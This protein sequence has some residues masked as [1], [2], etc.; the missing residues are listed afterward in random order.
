MKLLI[1]GGTG[2]IGKNLKDFFFK[3]PDFEL[4][5]PTRQQLNLLDDNACSDYLKNL[6]PDFVVHSAVDI[7]SVENS[8]KSFL[9]IFN[10]HAYFGHMIQ[11]GSGAEYD[12]RY[13]SPLMDETVFGRKIP[14]DTYGLA[15]FS[16]ANILER[17]KSK[18][19]TNLRI[20]GIYGKYED[21]SRRFISNNICRVLA[22]FPIAMN[23]NMLFD[24]IHVDD[25]ARFLVELFPKLPLPEVSYNFCSGKPISFVEL[26]EKVRSVMGVNS[27]IVIK[28]SGMNPEYS[29]NPEK[30]LTKFPNYRFSAYDDN[31]AELVDFYEKTLSPETVLAFKESL[32]E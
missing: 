25:F 27:D 4:Y 7:N 18:K 28:N 20:F 2:F 3:L 30:I 19:F 15:K 5:A 16:I 1:V 22:G 12:R 24:Y 8:L 17:D 11:I 26:A 31:I 21:Y 14:I 23:K 29:G 13:Y 6:K 32:V 9:N 10:S